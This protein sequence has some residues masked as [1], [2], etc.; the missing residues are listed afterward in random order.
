MREI[1]EKARQGRKERERE[2]YREDAC[3]ESIDRMTA[4][5]EKDAHARSNVNMPHA[6]ETLIT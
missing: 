1:R 4:R 3:I 2:S 6:C 5:T